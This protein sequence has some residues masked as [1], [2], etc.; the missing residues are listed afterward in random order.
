MSRDLKSGCFFIVFSLLILYESLR[1]GPG[2]PNKP[3]A[4]FLAFCA[5]IVLFV[6]SL[7]LVYRGWKIRESRMT[8]SQR[9]ILTFGVLFAYSLLLGILG[10]VVATFLG[11]TALF[12]LQLSRP[13]WTVLGTSALV[14]LLAYLVFGMLLRVYFPVGFLG[15]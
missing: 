4:G 8:H 15:I 14:T 9:V 11:L 10:F 5:A 7:A 13:W 12:R 1:L 6:L 2:S 3:G